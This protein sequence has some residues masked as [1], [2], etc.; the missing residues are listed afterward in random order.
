M[1]QPG[2]V[3][4]LGFLE[5]DF[6]VYTKVVESVSAEEL[7]R[8][9]QVKTR[10]G[11]VYYPDAFRGSQSLKRYGKHHTINHSKALVSRRQPWN[12]RN[13]IEGFGSYGKHILYHYR[14][15]SKY[16]FPMY[17]KEIDYRLNHRTE[18]LFK[19]FLKIY[20]GYISP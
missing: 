14:G 9:I 13:G 6:R 17:S 3:S 4:C 15:I 8:H 11:S 10:K 12:H 1:R 20:F 2:K 7:M 18:N 19:R 5:R 16:Y